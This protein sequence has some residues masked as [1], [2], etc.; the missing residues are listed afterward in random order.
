MSNLVIVIVINLI[1]SDHLLMIDC[2]FVQGK[3]YK[4]TKVTRLQLN[5]GETLAEVAK[6]NTSNSCGN[7]ETACDNSSPMKVY[8]GPSG[9][10]DHQSVI[11]FINNFLGLLLFF[12]YGLGLTFFVYIKT[13]NKTC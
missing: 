8:L 10:A 4:V 9:A 6:R 2:I 3:T 11:Q 5:S 13:I 1:F 12:Y 7:S